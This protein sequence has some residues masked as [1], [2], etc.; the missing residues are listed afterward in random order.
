MTE[1]SKRILEP[2]GGSTRLPS[3]ETWLLQR[4]WTCRKTDYGMNELYK[5]SYICEI[6]GSPSGVSEVSLGE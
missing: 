2:E 6:W 1:G 4:I 5:V 3:V